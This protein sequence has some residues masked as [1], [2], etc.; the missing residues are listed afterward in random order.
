MRAHMAGALAWLA[1][2]AVV[3]AASASEPAVLQNTNC[4]APPSTLCLHNSKIIRSFSSVDAGSCCANCTAE[5]KCVSWNINTGM[6]NCFLRGNY[7]TNSGRNCISGQVR[8]GPPPP[9]PP[10]PRP[11]PPPPPPTFVGVTCADPAFRAAPYCNRSLSDLGRAR[12]IVGA[13]SLP[14]KVLTLGNTNYGVAR[15][16]I[17]PMQFGE[18]L[19]GVATGCGAPA[20]SAPGD[21]FG[22]RTGCATSFPAGIAEGATFNKSL[23]LAVGAVIGREARALHNQPQCY[24][25]N[26]CDNVSGALSGRGIAGLSLWAPDMNLFRDPRWGRSATHLATHLHAQPRTIPASGCALVST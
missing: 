19:H 25:Q 6:K 14:E 17:R 23:W 8:P 9:P 21:R 2:G 5:P 11:P 20:A 22:P 10:P 13:M 4:S 18:G 3:H 12:A 26:N 7:V 1:V 15:L 24:G 16:G